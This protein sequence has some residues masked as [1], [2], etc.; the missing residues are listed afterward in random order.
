MKTIQKEFKVF[1]F[2]E[3]KPEIQNKVLDKFRETQE[4]LF[5]VDLSWLCEEIAEKL[6]LNFEEK[7]FE[8]EMFSRSN[9]LSLASGDV[10]EALRQK[11]PELSDLDIPEK[12]G[13]YQNYLG[14]DMCSSLKNSEIDENAVILEE[15]QDENE[16]LRRNLIRIK[17]KEDLEKLQEILAEAYRGFYTYHAE[18]V[19]DEYVKDFIEANEYEFLEN[20]EV[21]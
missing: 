6:N 19:S 9:H 8:Y 2:D 3:L 21:F 4:E 1:G 16:D 14:G 11:Y 7:D 13:V 18:V 10:L 15:E 20:G 5:E 17:I 12:F